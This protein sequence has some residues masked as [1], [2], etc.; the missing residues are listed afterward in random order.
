[1]I[2]KLVNADK[3]SYLWCNRY[4][5]NPLITQIFREISRTG[6]GYLYVALALVAWLINNS[7]GEKFL[8]AGLLAFAMELPIYFILK[9]A[10]KRERPFIHLHGARFALIPSDQFSLPS[11]HTAGA[12][13]MASI[14]SVVFPGF[15]ALA[16]IWAGL[17]GLS[18]V[19]LGVHYPSDIIAGACLGISSAYASMIIMSILSMPI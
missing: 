18:R 1:M 2:D 6:D 19:M 16:F 5:S 13:L 4:Q 8:I 14:I 9:S 17:I 11:G 7:T 15:S 3:T 10:F 12:F